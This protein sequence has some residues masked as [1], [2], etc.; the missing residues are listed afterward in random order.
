MW[1]DRDPLALDPAA[2]VVQ[3]SEPQVERWAEYRDRAYAAGRAFV[4]AVDDILPIIHA[5]R[6]VSEQQGR[7]ADASVAAMV[8]PA[9]ISPIS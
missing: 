1:T 4:A 9:A 2:P 5:G 6:T 7:V 3:T 8:A